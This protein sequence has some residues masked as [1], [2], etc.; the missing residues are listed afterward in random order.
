M[1]LV[2]ELAVPTKVIAALPGPHVEPGLKLLE[3][4]FPNIRV[5]YARL[6]RFLESPENLGFG[7][8]FITQG[9]VV[10]EG[11]RWTYLH[12]ADPPRLEFAGVLV[13]TVEEREDK[14]W[15]I[16]PVLVCRGS[17]WNDEEQVDKKRALT[18]L[19]LA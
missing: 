4:D 18:L 19:G 14:W 3:Q 5:D 12:S 11:K 13:Y 2:R 1:S 16:K 8:R 17:R 6:V 10:H 7:T 9:N 15:E